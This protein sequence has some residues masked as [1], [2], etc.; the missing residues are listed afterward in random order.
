MDDYPANRLLLS[1][2]LNYLG[3]NVLDEQDGAHGLRAW[4]NNHFDVVITDCNMP[5]MNGYELAKAIRAE[6][7][8]SGGPPLL[9]L[10]FTAN[11]QPEEI[12]RCAA[13]GMDDCLFKPIGMKELM[14]RLSEW[15]RCLNKYPI[16]TKARHP[17]ILI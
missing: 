1:Q 5:V 9:I 2:Q 17:M 4:R 7:L 11:A 6:E 15:S 8:L 16:S 14:A 3:H 10:G 12:E 13:A